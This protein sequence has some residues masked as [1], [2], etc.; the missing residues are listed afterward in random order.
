[1]GKENSESTHNVKEKD[2]LWDLVT[3]GEKEYHKE[4]NCE[5]VNWMKLA[6]DWV[7]WQGF[8]SMVMNFWV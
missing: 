5:N 7:Q 8:L 2:H 6:Q 4:V 1:M 3:N